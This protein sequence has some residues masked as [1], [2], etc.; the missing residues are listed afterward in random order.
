MKLSISLIT[1]M[2]FTLQLTQLEMDVHEH[3][4]EMEQK[5]IYLQ[6]SLEKSELTIKE[7]NKQV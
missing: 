2:L 7:R 6:G 4:T 5:I 1:Q 3:K